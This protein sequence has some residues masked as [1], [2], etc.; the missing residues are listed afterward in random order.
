MKDVRVAEANR[1]QGANSFRDTAKVLKMTR[2]AVA[3]MATG[4]AMGAYEAALK[5]AQEQNL[6]T[7][8]RGVNA[9]ANGGIDR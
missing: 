4:F 5:Y 3:W 1:L 7:L 6:C 8:P 9:C 2:Y